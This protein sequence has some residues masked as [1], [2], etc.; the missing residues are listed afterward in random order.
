MATTP[1]K[2]SGMAAIVKIDGID[3]HSFGMIVNRVDNPVPSVKQSMLSIPGR[4]GDLDFANRYGPRS[5]TL[6]G[7]I[8]GDTTAQ[9]LSNLDELNSWLRL[10]ENR[11]SMQLIFQNQT[12]R[13]WRVRYEG[14][15]NISNLGPFHIGAIVNYSIQFKCIAPYAEAVALTTATDYHL[16]AGTP[17]SINYAGNVP[18]PLN[19][20][21]RTFRP[22]NLAVDFTEATT[23]WTPSANCGIS[24]PTSPIYGTKCLLLEPTDGAAF[25]AT[26][27]VELSGGSII[28]AWVMSSISETRDFKLEYET[29]SPGGVLSSYLSSVVADRWYRLQ[30]QVPDG[31]ASG[32]TYERIN[33]HV[34]AG[35]SGVDVF[36]DGLMIRS[37]SDDEVEDEDFFEIPVTREDGSQVHSVDPT[38]ILSRGINKLRNSFLDWTLSS[39]GLSYSP[40]EDVNCIVIPPLSTAT[41][42]MFPV[43]QTREYTLVFWVYGGIDVDINLYGDV[44]IGLVISSD[45]YSAAIGAVE[46]KTVTFTVPAG[47]YYAEVIMTN[48]IGN[49]T[50]VSK[51]MLV[52]SSAS[53]SSHFEP[54]IVENGYTCSL[55][56]QRIA[57]DTKNWSGAYTTEADG[58][59]A[60]AFSVMDANSEPLYLKP[61]TNELYYLDKRVGIADPDTVASGAVTISYSYRKRYL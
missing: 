48:N 4:H 60:S 27:D 29:D 30:I 61:G 20:S 1:A 59:T 41:S 45:S 21:L 58:E 34:G 40:E 5:I 42:P 52:E 18:A 10:R 35:N 6:S 13:Y 49:F 43:M 55:D 24:A 46:K 51:V 12:D 44:T 50:F 47:Y 57:F 23:D 38:L 15:F 3:L 2:L 28:S 14:V 8:I 31:H 9:L 26:H 39:A 33:I 25:N 36:W 56:G 22:S 54:D 16:I 32:G 19:Y 37:I 53:T 17:L 7:A 11:D